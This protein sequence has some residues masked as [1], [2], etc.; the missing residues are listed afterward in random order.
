MCLR[1]T[2]LVETGAE[3]VAHRIQLEGPGPLA[4]TLVGV[5]WGFLGF[6]APGQVFPGGKECLSISPVYLLLF[7]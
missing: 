6:W 1:N 2:G 4:R 5:G 7:L 3:P